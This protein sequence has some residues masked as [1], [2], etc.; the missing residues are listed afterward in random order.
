MG[1]DEKNEKKG[2]SFLGRWF[3][4]LCALGWSCQPG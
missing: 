1:D 4:R 2:P 3:R